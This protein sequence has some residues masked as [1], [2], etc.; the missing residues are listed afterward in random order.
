MEFTNCKTHILK[1]HNTENK[2]CTCDSEKIWNKS[3]VSSEHNN[4]K[5]VRIFLIEKITGVANALSRKQEAAEQ[6]RRKVAT[7]V[8]RKPQISEG[9][10][11]EEMINQCLEPNG[12]FPDAEQCDKY[13]DC[14]DGKFTEKLCPD[15][16]VFNDFSPQHEKCDLPFGIDCTK[17][18]KL[19]KNS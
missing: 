4:L 9:K 5:F 18:P 14:R 2:N 17:R 10:E 16:L 12:Y 1:I 11:L 7:P 3:K 6:G 8:Q 15:G 13:Y 19:R